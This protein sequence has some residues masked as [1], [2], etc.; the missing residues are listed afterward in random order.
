MYSSPPP[1]P[2]PTPTLTSWPPSPFLTTSSRSSSCSSS[3]SSSFY[4]MGR[5]DP[6]ILS[7]TLRP[8]L[9]HRITTVPLHRLPKEYLTTSTCASLGL[10]NLQEHLQELHL[11]E[12]KN[13]PE[14]SELCSNPKRREPTISHWTRTKN[15]KHTQ[16]VPVQN[17]SQTLCRSRTDQ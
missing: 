2:P 17:P 11:Q 12:Y 10:L 14:T 1:P 15:Q 6:R 13:V 7:E 16:P 4:R 8:S 3:L 9:H 5:A